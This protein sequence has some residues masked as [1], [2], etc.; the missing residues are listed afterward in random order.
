MNA[1]T[2]FFPH[3][4][5]SQKKGC[6]KS[7]FLG[8]CGSGLIDGI[9]IGSYTKSID[10]KKYGLDAIAALRLNPALAEDKKAL[11]TI[12]MNGVTKKENSQ[13]DVV[14]ALWNEGLVK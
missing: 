6:P 9:P 7:T 11:W 5:E 10:N 14:I 4:K 8:I 13:M 3:S 2:E 1:V 12:I